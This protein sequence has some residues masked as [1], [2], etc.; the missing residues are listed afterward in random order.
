MSVA[1]TPRQDAGEPAPETAPDT[2][3]RMA[4]LLAQQ[5]GLAGQQVFLPHGGRLCRVPAGWQGAALSGDPAVAVC[6]SL[7]ELDAAV[8]DANKPVIF[9]PADA[10]MTTEDIERVCQ[11]HG[12]KT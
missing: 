5:E 3:R 4:V 2:L 7:R 1:M 12:V 8:R 11:R 9:L 10:M 6:A